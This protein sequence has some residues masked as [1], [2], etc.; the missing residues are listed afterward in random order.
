MRI[1]T[2]VGNSAARV[3]SKDAEE[4]SGDS[5]VP[6]SASVRIETFRSGPLLIRACR[7]V[8]TSS[9]SDLPM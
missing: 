6:R 8:A 7:R 3:A 4:G 2:W 1:S 9:C 5:R